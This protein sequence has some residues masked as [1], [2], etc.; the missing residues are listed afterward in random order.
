MTARAKP[1][2][3]RALIATPWKRSVLR[4]GSNSPLD[5]RAHS[6]ASGL[7][8]SCCTSFEHERAAQYRRNEADRERRCGPCCTLRC[9][10]SQVP[11]IH[12][13]QRKP[14]IVQKRD[15]EGEHPIRQRGQPRKDE[16]GAAAPSHWRGP[17]CKH[18]P[19]HQ[20]LVSQVVSKRHART[21]P[22]ASKTRC[23]RTCHGAVFGRPSAG[24]DR[25]AA[26]EA[27][28][29]STSDAGSMPVTRRSKSGECG[30]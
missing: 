4:R 9:A 12:T 28:A 13:A 11:A 18:T 26:A 21:S 6:S 7:T 1:S 29:E 24:N 16:S 17:H 14:E 27:A 3:N 15:K 30:S 22:A 20:T 5:A 10:V 2:W 23:A 19:Q 25:P 8:W